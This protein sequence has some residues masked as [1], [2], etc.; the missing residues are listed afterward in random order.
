[1]CTRVRA[2]HGQNPSCTI[3][4]RGKS[5]NGGEGEEEGERLSKRYIS[6]TV[7]S[8]GESCLVFSSQ[9]VQVPQFLYSTLPIGQSA[10][11]SPPWLDA[12]PDSRIHDLSRGGKKVSLSLSLRPWWYEIRIH[13]KACKCR[14]WHV[15]NSAWNT[16][17]FSSGEF[18][19]NR[20]RGTISVYSPW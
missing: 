16:W 1:M 15:N 20:R 9:F 4:K 13:G 12:W 8:H 14:A 17:N 6:L 18:W 10:G 19:T 2:T 3:A 5:L 7:E 11:V